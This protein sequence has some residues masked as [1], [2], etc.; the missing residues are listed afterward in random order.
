MPITKGKIKKGREAVDAY[1][2]THT[3]LY[4]DGWYKGIPEAHTPLSIWN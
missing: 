2:T 4:I 1:R 3:G